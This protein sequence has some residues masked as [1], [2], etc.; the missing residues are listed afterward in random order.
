MIVFTNVSLKGRNC[1]SHQSALYMFMFCCVNLKYTTKQE[2]Y[3]IVHVK[4]SCT[5]EMG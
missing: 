2:Y 3:C 5:V 4:V 1:S